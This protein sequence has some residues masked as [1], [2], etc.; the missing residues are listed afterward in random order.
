MPKMHRFW[1]FCVNLLFA[2]KNDFRYNTAFATAAEAWMLGCFV[3]FVGLTQ[4]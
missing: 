3:Y 4:Y 1:S 2:A